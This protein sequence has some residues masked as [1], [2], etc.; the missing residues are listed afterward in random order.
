[1]VAK[2]KV[3]PAVVTFDGGPAALEYDRSDRRREYQIGFEVLHLN[4]GQLEV[5]IVPHQDR[6]LP[7]ETHIE[8]EGAGCLGIQLGHDRHQHI[9]L[10]KFGEF[11]ANELQQVGLHRR[12]RGSRAGPDDG[13]LLEADK[14]GLV[15]RD[16]PG[17]VGCPFGR[18]CCRNAL[19]RSRHSRHELC[20]R[21]RRSKLFE[22]G[23]FV[24]VLGHDAHDPVVLIVGRAWKEGADR[25]PRSKQDCRNGRGL[26]VLATS[27]HGVLHHATVSSLT[28]CFSIAAP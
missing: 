1:M 18:L 14:I 23:A 25:E 11:V 19:E 28:I 27:K 10:A 2:R 20:R 8:A 5:P 26:M 16:F 3:R 7:G 9:A 6:V 22:V 24:D 12:C 15:L 4:V 21:R 13:D 17:D